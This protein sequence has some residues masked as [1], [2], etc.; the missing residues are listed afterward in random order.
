MREPTTSEIMAKAPLAIDKKSIPLKNPG[1]RPK[2]YG[3]NKH[4]WYS[5]EDRIKVATVYAVVGNA[6]RTEEITGIPSYVVRKW[7]QQEWWPQIIDRIRQEKDDELDTKLTKIVDK[8]VEEINDRVEQGDHFYN[9][10]T[11]E[12]IRKP[13][14]GRELVV[15][16]STFLGNREKL[17]SKQGVSS[18]QT[19]IQERLERIAQ[20]IRKL[21]AGG[22]NVIEGEVITDAT[23]AD[24]IP[25]TDETKQGQEILT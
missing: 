5:E 10:V 15:I 20:D 21:V 13:M 16:A 18:A 3:H 22:N 14:D 4:K 24:S 19:S 11:G 23:E 8:A 1:G 6:S 7:K 2:R 25:A 9:A 12:I 17:R